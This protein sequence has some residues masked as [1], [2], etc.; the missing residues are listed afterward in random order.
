MSTEDF[1][2]LNAYRKDKFRTDKAKFL[3]QAKKDDDGGWFKHTQHHWSRYVRAC[4]LDYWPSRKKFQYEGKVKRG[5]VYA[6][7]R[8]TELNNV[9][10]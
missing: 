2:A 7:I 4:R 5:D 9:P 6:F 8:E 3:A 10:P 1:E